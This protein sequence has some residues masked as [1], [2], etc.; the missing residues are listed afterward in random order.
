MTFRRS[1]FAL[2]LLAA[3]GLHAAAWEAVTLFDWVYPGE[4]A[5][6]A[7]QKGVQESGSKH[8]LA[9]RL[10]RGEKV[11]QASARDLAAELMDDAAVDADTKA[12]L[13]Q[14]LSSEASALGVGEQSESLKSTESMSALLD[15]ASKRIDEIEATYKLN[16]YGKSGTPSLNMLI[17]S[18]WHNDNYGG[19]LQRR[20]KGLFYNA[21]ELTLDTS[22]KNDD[23]Q[24]GLDVE[25]NAGDSYMLNRS[26]M[27]PK[28]VV[29]ASF[30]IPFDSGG[31]SVDFGDRFAV[32]MSPLLLGSITYEGREQFF[33]DMISYYP[34]VKTFKLM[35]LDYPAATTQYHALAIGRQGQTWYWPFSRTKLVY[36]PGDDQYW[37]GWNGKNYVTALRLDRDLQQNS[38][39]DPGIY[40]V[41]VVHS[42]SDLDAFRAA[43]VTIPTSPPLGIP[44]KRTV[45]AYGAGLETHF[46]T[47]TQFKVDWA[48]SNYMVDLNVNGPTRLDQDQAFIS[49]LSQPIGP[50]SVAL[51]AGQVGPYFTTIPR[52]TGRAEL[53]A[54]TD[55]ME[56]S[57]T[58]TNADD[59]KSWV[60]FMKDSSVMSNNESLLYAKTEWNA[61]WFSLGLYEGL[62]SQINPTD[63]RVVIVP[64][65][66]ARTDNGYGWFRIL[67]ESYGPPSISPGSGNGPLGTDAQD[68]FNRLTNSNT[69]GVPSA[70]YTG[71]ATAQ[72]VNWQQLSQL[73]YREA[74]FTTYLTTNGV[75]DNHLLDPVA[76]T[77]N[78]FGFRALFDLGSLFLR[79]LPSKLTVVGELRD[80]ALQ[81]GFPSLDASN[82]FSQNYGYAVYEHGLSSLYSLLFRVGYETW[83]SKRDYYPLDMQTL[84]YGAGLD[85]FLDPYLTG[86]K[87]NIR[88]N[89]MLF[90]DLNLPARNFSLF[91]LDLGATLSY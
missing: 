68:A 70:V 7:L 31:L 8:W 48:Y 46:L 57:Y 52:N 47:G 81:P 29:A 5:Y 14:K 77:F 3:A 91:T 1:F 49:S 56:M 10:Q 67:G 54:T 85:I 42:A 39:M 79:T 16:N 40:Y 64:A 34:P 61:G 58:G 45:D 43:G 22:I 53:G 37:A 2:A 62:L 55:S 69:P 26:D 15:K 25:E 38:W 24:F 90:S 35:D 36:T 71:G 88:G 75:G 87:I 9:A 60:T 84:E 23:V 83:K 82:L 27:Q 13:K 72:K 6:T 63:A 78:I 65:L 80:L 18:N 17:F 4:A 20:S 32:F 33:V 76:K 51:Q 66:E 28:V 21:A 19:M 50:V 41:S 11:P 89:Q 59:P 86:L 30:Q 12:V 44:A 74:F 73:S